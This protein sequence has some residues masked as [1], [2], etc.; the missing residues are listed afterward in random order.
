MNAFD[1]KLFASPLARIVRLEVVSGET[2][3]AGGFEPAAAR[4]FAE[5]MLGACDVAEGKMDTELALLFLAMGA[6]EKGS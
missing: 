4:A 2:T 6:S 5:A 1:L 3:I